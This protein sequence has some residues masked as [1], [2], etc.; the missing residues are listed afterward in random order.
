MV[1]VSAEISLP[2]VWTCDTKN[3]SHFGRLVQLLKQTVLYF[4]LEAS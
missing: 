2:S 3:C 1:V 4:V